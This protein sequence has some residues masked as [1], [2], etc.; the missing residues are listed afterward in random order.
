MI[1]ILMNAMPPILVTI[2]QAVLIDQEVTGVI[3]KLDT[4]APAVNWI[5]MNVQATLVRMVERVL[6]WLIHLTVSVLMNTQVCII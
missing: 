6:T 2:V 5:L 4:V 1:L 3:V